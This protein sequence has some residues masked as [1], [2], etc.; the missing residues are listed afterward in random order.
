M[1]MR[2]LH[3]D[4]LG[5]LHLLRSTSNRAYVRYHHTIYCFQ[6]V[7]VR[8]KGEREGV[9]F[10]STPRRYYFLI[11]DARTIYC[12][13]NNRSYGSNRIDALLEVSL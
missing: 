7:R 10:S 1:N 8:L 3:I 13:Q 2:I 4:I 9:E 6:F 5:F 12:S 11:A